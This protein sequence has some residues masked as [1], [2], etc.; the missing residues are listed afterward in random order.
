MLTIKQRL[1]ITTDRA[2]RSILARIAKRD[3]VP[4]ATKAA[5][6]L[7]NALELEEDIALAKIANERFLKKGKF[8]P[9]ELAWK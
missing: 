6:L 4:L 5:Q 2:T 8:I 3:R 7:R 9:H 1:N